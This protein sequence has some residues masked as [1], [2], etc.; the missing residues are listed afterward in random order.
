MTAAAAI[1]AGM[2][3]L[4]RLR[5]HGIGSLRHECESRRHGG[6]LDGGHVVAGCDDSRYGYDSSGLGGWNG[7]GYGSHADSVHRQ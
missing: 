3:V 1:M 7:S 5:G 6:N 4:S 2:L